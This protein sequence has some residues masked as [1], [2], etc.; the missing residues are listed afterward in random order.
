MWIRT[1]FGHCANKNQ[2][3]TMQ[4]SACGNLPDSKKSMSVYLKYRQIIY[5]HMY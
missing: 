5:V 2:V 4:F 3:C 1:D